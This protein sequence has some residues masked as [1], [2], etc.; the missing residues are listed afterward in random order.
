MLRHAR[1]VSTGIAISSI[2][3]RRTG[4]CMSCVI[5]QARARFALKR[6]YVLCVVP[7]SSSRPFN[8]AAVTP[9]R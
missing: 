6:V 9:T 1:F 7:L 8:C 3:S 5:W 4:A 2:M